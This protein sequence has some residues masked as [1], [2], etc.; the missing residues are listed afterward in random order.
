MLHVTAKKSN[1]AGVL[2]EQRIRVRKDVKDTG[3][4]YVMLA[5]VF[6]S[7]V[8]LFI[9]IS[10]RVNVVQYGYELSMA[11]SERSRLMEDNRRLRV[12]QTKLSSPQRI[13]K[14]GI[15]VLGLVYPGGEQVILVK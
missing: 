7:L 14:L 12:E 11:N 3:F 6:V 15:E 8:F 10:S 13:E 9:Y 1:A 4:L 2:V 5:V